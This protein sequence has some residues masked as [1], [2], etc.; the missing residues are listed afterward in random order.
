LEK[1]IRSTVVNSPIGLIELSA[2]QKGLFS[3]KIG[4]T[5]NSRG[6]CCD[7]EDVR[8]V[9]KS[10]ECELKEYFECRRREFSVKL[11]IVGSRFDVMVWS[12]LRSIPYGE[13][14]S[15]RWLAEQIGYP[16][17]YRAVGRALSRNPLPIF[18]P[19][20]RVVRADGGLGGYRVGVDVKRFLL[21]LERENLVRS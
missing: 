17:A 5:L 20:H 16:N 10:A 6:W 19:C 13:V 7:D 3:V 12:A 8:E 9:L 1:K 21:R 2:T 18:L 11:D 15:Y 14:R 4:C